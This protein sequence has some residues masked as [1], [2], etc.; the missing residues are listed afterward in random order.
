MKKEDELFVEFSEFI[1]QILELILDDS[2]LDAIYQI[3]L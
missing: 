3:H 1:P 2:P